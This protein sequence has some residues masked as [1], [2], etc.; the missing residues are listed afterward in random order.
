[1]EKS[2]PTQHATYTK[3]PV[4]KHVAHLSAVMILGF[5]AMT[6][7]QLIELLYIG[8]LGTQQLA[9]IT[10]MFPI[11]MALNALTRGIGMGAATIIA[12]AMGESDRDATARTITH[13]YILV[14]AFTCSI[15]VIGVLTAESVFHGL[16]AE[17]TVLSLTVGY[18]HIWFIGFP[19]MGIAM[20]SNGLIRSFGNATYPGYIMSSAPIVQVIVGP[21]LIFGWLGLPA[22]GLMGAAWAFVIG[23]LLQLLLAAYWYLIKESLVHFSVAQF[24]QSTT[25]ILTVGIPAAATNLIQ[26]LST[27]F[28]TW[29]LSQ[30]GTTVVAGFGVASRIEAVAGMVVIGIGTSVVPLV[31]QNWG[32]R[33]FKR[34]QQTLTTCYIACLSWGLIAAVIMWFGAGFFISS[35]SDNPDLMESAVTF[36]HIIPIS[37]GF[38][39]LITVANHAF[40]ALRRP[41]PAL[42]LSISR[43]VI[44]YVPLA[45]LGS[46][47]YGYAGI[48]AATAIAN[49]M[50]GLFAI[51]WYQR[52]MRSAKS[53]LLDQEN[54]GQ[55]NPKLLK[56]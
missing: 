10:Y 32:A 40:N 4:V 18:A 52:V 47:L 48:F 15:S 30:F 38:M 7:G 42:I 43:L 31:G 46:Y 19:C 50:V 53:L 39:G 33:Q 3:G 37:I 17:N 26:P 23:S 41:I 29:M 35:I 11:A 1:V 44:V 56:A 27:A 49:I 2:H 12:Q 16:G 55:T 28:A 24:Y 8:R 14:L 54:E 25:Q 5:L 36:L 34:V 51:Y 45:F 21:F 20:V 6:L 13:C 9:A 22:M